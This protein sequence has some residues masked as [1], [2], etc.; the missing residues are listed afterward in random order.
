MEDIVIQRVKQ[1][2]A[3]LHN[4]NVSAFANTIGMNQVTINDYI[5]GKRKPSLALAYNILQVHSEISAEWLMRGEGE[6]T[7]SRFDRIIDKLQV[8]CGNKNTKFEDINIQS[9]D[10]HH[11][12][13]DVSTVTIEELK[14]EKERLMRI[15][16]N[17]TKK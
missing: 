3:K 6:M 17:L 14:E 5:N 4:G 9:L 13:Q 10:E 1:I 15:I 11:N 12:T 2:V 8:G 7:R 16:E